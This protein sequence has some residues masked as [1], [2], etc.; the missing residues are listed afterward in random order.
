[1][2]KKKKPEEEKPLVFQQQISATNFLQ[3]TKPAGT[4]ILSSPF[5]SMSELMGFSYALK[6]YYFND[7]QDDKI[8]L[9]VG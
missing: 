4:I 9:G 7:K 6:K 8:P 3:V 2:T 1:M 5:H